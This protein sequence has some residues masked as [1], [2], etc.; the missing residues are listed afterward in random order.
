MCDTLI[1][2]HKGQTWFA[3]NSDREPAEP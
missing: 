3:K 1:L 2:R